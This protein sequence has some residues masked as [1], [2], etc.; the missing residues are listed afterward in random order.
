MTELGEFDDI[1][2]L[3]RMNV[4]EDMLSKIP[5]T[6]CNECSK[7]ITFQVALTYLIGFGVSRNEDQ[8]DYWLH[9]SGMKKEDMD[10]AISL[11]K[12]KYRPTGRLADQVKN[13]IGL[14]ALV[15]L[16][17]AEQYQIEGRLLEAGEM[18]SSEISGRERELGENHTSTASLKSELAQIY[19]IQGRLNEA[20]VL[21]QE[22]IAVRSQ[23]LDRGHPSIV[24]SIAALARI[25]GEQGRLRDAEKLQLGVLNAFEQQLG[26]KHPDTLAAQNNL[27]ITLLLQGCNRDAEAIFRKNLESRTETLTTEH[28]LTMRASTLLFLCLRLQGKLQE[29]ERLMLEIKN[30]STKLARD[31][32]VAQGFVQ[33]NIAVLHSD[34]SRFDEAESIAIEV[35]DS[36]GKTLGE[37][38]LTTLYAR[39]SLVDIYYAKGQPKEAEKHLR[40]CL[41]GT[42]PLGERNSTFLRLKIMLAQ[43]L[44]KQNL[45][46]ESILQAQEVLAMYQGSMAM[47][48]HNVLACT[49]FLASGY[50]AIGQMGDAENTRSQL[51]LSCRK[52]LGDKHPL[53]MR[54]RSAFA[55]S[56]IDQELWREAETLEKEV[57]LWSTELLE[58]DKIAVTSCLNLALIYRE[59]GR[60]SDGE[61]LAEIG[62]SWS[63]ECYGDSHFETKLA[64]NFLFGLHVRAG[65]LDKAESLYSLK[66]S[67]GCDGLPNNRLM[68][69]VKKNLADL[70]L[71]QGEPKAAQ[72]LLQEAMRLSEMTSHESGVDAVKLASNMLASK[73]NEKLTDEVEAKALG[74]IRLKE[75]MFGE[76]HATTLMTISDLAYIYALNDR[77]EDSGKLFG[78]LED[79]VDQ[80]TVQNRVNFAHHCFKRAEFYYLTRQYH[81]ARKEEETSLRIRQDIL[82]G[83]HK[84]TLVSMASLSSTLNA[85]EMYDEA[86]RYMRHVLDVKLKTLPVNDI[87]TLRSKKDLAAILFYQNRL[88]ESEGLYA[89]V[90]DASLRIFGDCSFTRDQT[91]CLSIVRTKKRG[92]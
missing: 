9:R 11:L 57:Y 4:I 40:K 25:M 54:A 78:K 14:G 5:S 7:R 19:R 55:Q 79:L 71:A 74:L 50:A 67:S 8:S 69:E 35:V 82:G 41:D 32:F 66:L 36:F 33:M 13:A 62:I 16:D 48:P 17:R 59:Q 84:L 83:E 20:N 38:D 22:I 44:L 70:R 72:E 65:S 53:T 34:Q 58:H 63:E 56:Y 88:E 18:L 89:E 45:F 30:R 81:K 2:Y 49:E 3:F 26:E 87:S 73:T 90:V 85:L 28:P 51:V 47:D 61:K 80:N 6:T 76:K 77:L 37:H 52:E 68:M 92:L 64:V 39:E 31:D 27:G 12:Q 23:T 46:A 21:Q 91:E 42:K 15:T 29:A 43:N 24:T 75:Q 10:E 60:F 86:E 1:D